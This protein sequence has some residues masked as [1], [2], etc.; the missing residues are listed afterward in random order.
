[1]ELTVNDFGISIGGLFVTADEDHYSA[2]RYFP[3]QKYFHFLLSSVVPIGSQLKDGKAL[4]SNAFKYC[5]MVA[6]SYAV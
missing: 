1:M 2:K 6:Y 4:L 3:S 5:L